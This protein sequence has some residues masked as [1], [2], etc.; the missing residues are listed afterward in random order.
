MG[1]EEGAARY[2]RFEEHPCVPKLRDAVPGRAAARPQRR[3]L[4]DRGWRENWHCWPD[5]FRQELN[6]RVNFPMVEG[7]SGSILLN[8][9]DIST[10]GLKDLRES[11]CMIPQDPF[12]FSG[13]L[14]ENIDPFN[15]VQADKESGMLLRWSG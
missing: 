12:L 7:S 13:T 8:G 2:I 6:P 9:V 3:V 1:G 11:M 10:L 4:H 15:A 5:R 14:R